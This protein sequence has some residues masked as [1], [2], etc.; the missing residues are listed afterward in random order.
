[1]DESTQMGTQTSKAQLEKIQSY[2]DYAK[3]SDAEILVGG[4]QIT[5]NGLDKGFFFE[6]T[7]IAVSDNKNKLA[8]EE[9]FGPV[10]TIIKVKDDEEAIRVANDSDYGLAGGVFSRNITRALNIAKSVRT[11][12][13]WINTYNQVPEGAPFGG[14][15]KSGIGRE[16]YKEAIKN[17]QQ[18]KNIYIDTSDALKGLY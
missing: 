10:L 4:S 7:L 2:V 15:K 6:P 12:R 3:E 17:Y 18:V 1:M 14:Y 5:E 9:I 16:T 11:G 8:Q 13:I